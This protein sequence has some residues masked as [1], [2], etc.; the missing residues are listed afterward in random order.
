[1][2]YTCIFKKETF[3]KDLTFRLDLWCLMPLSTIFQ[4]YRGGGNQSTW[5]KTT[6]PSEVTDKLY[7]IML[8]LAMN[9]VQTHNFSG[10]RH[11]LHR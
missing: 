8:Y 1:M 7:Y 9:G 2:I 11:L 3:L 4:V 5:T 10:D 6:D